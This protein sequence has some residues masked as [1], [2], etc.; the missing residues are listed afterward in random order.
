MGTCAC[1]LT[2]FLKRPGGTVK[3]LTTKAS[4]QRP[5]DNQILNAADMH[6]FCNDNIKGISFCF[7]NGDTMNSIR[8]SLV[9]RFQAVKTVPGT[10]CYHQYEPI[11]EN[12]IGCKRV[13]GY[14]EFDLKFELFSDIHKTTQ[15]EISNCVLCIYDECYWIGMVCDSGTENSYVKI[16]FMHPLFPSCSYCWPCR[17]DICWV[18]LSKVVTVLELPSLTS[19]TGRQYHFSNKTVTNIT[20]A[21]NQ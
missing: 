5:I 4:L 20:N 7:V 3:R 13:S 10:R 1:D 19:V 17:E 18:P 21:I 12:V 11:N 9:E 2:P 15:V 8:A 6:N 16:K 14:I